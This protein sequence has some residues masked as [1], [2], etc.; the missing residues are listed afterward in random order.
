MVS[1]PTGYKNEIYKLQTNS[2]FVNE[3]SMYGTTG[4][5]LFAAVDSLSNVYVS[6]EENNIV[7]KYDSNGNYLSTIGLG[8]G[9]G[10]GYL[11]GPRGLSL[12]SS[13]NLYVADRYNS[14]VVKFNS[15]GAWV[16]N[17]TGSGELTA[18]SG[19]KVAGSDLYVTN[20]S[21]N[22]PVVVEMDSTSGNAVTYWGTYGTGGSGQIN[23][24]DGIDVDSSGNVYVSDFGN[25]FIQVFS[26]AGQYQRQISSHGSGVGQL[27]APEGI[28]VSG[29]NIYVSDGSL[30]EFTT[31]GTYVTNW[32]T[33]GG[34]LGAPSGLSGTSSDLYAASGQLVQTFDH[35]GDFLNR[36][37]EMNDSNGIT[38]GSA[39]GVAVDGSGNV[40][41]LDLSADTVDK[42]TSAGVP[43]T[44]WGGYGTGSGKFNNPK[45]IAVDSLGEVFVADTYNDLIQK[46]T[47]AG[48]FTTQWGGFGGG[49]FGSPCAVACDSS[50]NVYVV[51][52]TNS[53]VDKFTNAGVTL[54]QWGTQGAAFGQFND[55]MGVAVDSSNN[56]YVVDAGNARVQKFNSNG[57]LMTVWGSY[58]TASTQFYTPSAIWVDS[59]GYIYV[60]DY[61]YVKK[62][63][64]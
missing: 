58:G 2:V 54:I 53:R 26:S 6:D 62:F 37:G 40:Y 18:P 55:P 63:G 45:G 44:S 30:K 23:N 51:D 4:I 19:I 13:N 38:F 56:V 11:N 29:S 47:S 52:Q 3:W 15:S 42:F 34:I 9:S 36:W 20:I 12:D 57:G 59:S 61:D 22:N 39:T 25:G 35:S 21:N 14:R 46:F 31:S 16:A 48:V 33:P 7:I 43:I 10:N 50:N 49:G 27:G 60:S 28:V 24:P 17:L 32:T 5:A 8:A 1:L 41:V 64:P